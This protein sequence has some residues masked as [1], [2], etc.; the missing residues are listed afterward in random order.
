MWDTFF[1]SCF[2]YRF[3]W[4]RTQHN[5]QYLSI[6]LFHFL[7]ICDLSIILFSLFDQSRP[8]TKHTIL[9]SRHPRISRKRTKLKTPA[10]SNC[11]WQ[12]PANQAQ[13]PNSRYCYNSTTLVFYILPRCF[14]PGHVLSNYNR[15]LHSVPLK[16]HW[17]VIHQ[18][19][20]FVVAFEGCI[21]LCISNRPQLS[22]ISHSRNQFHI[23]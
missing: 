15:I 7:S 19:T 18:P 5:F 23:L 20:P 10:R 1:I 2:R 8:F 21:T 11:R 9:Y 13:R 22:W 12:M 14:V 6:C 4:N 3:R 17:V 16:S